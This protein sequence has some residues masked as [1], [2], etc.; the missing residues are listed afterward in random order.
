MQIDLKKFQETFFEEAAEHLSTMESGLLHL[1]ESGS[2]NEFLNTIFRAAHSIKGAAG[3]FDFKEIVRLTH[4]MENVLDKLR[5]NLLAPTADLTQILLR[6]SDRLREVVDA[7]H[8][9]EAGS[10][11]IDDILPELEAVLNGGQPSEAP[12]ADAA[13]PPGVPRGEVVYAVVFEPELE[14]FR[15]GQDLFLL[16]RELGELGE[17]LSSECQRS[18]LP[19]LD[20]LDPEHCY[21]GW[22]VRVRTARA[23]QE[24]RDVFMFV[25]GA[26]RLEVTAEAVTA[27]PEASAAGAVR[28]ERRAAADRRVESTS[29]RVSTEKV[30]GLINLVGELVISQAMVNQAVAALAMTPELEE[31]L[32]VVQRSTRELQE[33]VMAIRM[34]P[35]GTVF[36]RFPRLVHDL[37]VK[38]GK[39]ARLDIEGAETE[40]DKSVIEQLGDPLTHLIRNSIDHGIEDPEQRALAGKPEEGVITLRAYHEG[41]TVVIEVADDGKG[42]DRERIR[43][44]ALAQG[45]IRADQ[46]M[47][48]EEVNGLIFA[49]GFS[50]AA[51]VSDVSGRGVGMDVVKR[52]VESL[53]GAISVH[54][55]P[56]KGSRIR[57]RLP[58]TLA[59]L[60]GLSV[61]LGRDTFIV[62]LLSI[63]QSVRPEPS[64]IKTVLGG[65][66]E[67]FV[68]RGEPLPLVRLSRLFGVAGAVEDPQQGIVV[69]TENDGHRFGV[70][71]DDVLGQLQV[72]VKSI[73]RNYR[74]VEAVMGATILGD[75]RVAFIVDVAELHRV[76]TRRKSP[77]EDGRSADGAA[78]APLQEEVA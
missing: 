2:D 26:C 8:R 59:I 18:R 62:P 31:A 22:K 34:L 41:G 72:V 12:V 63:R 38:L 65:R 5:S 7:T 19:A 11:P 36:N 75:G 54:S 73:E 21:L 77:E 66:G 30:D 49:A 44:K 61:Q 35:I 40:L 55:T 24:L 39:R 51:V 52:N 74:K 43:A 50:T 20:E 4:V 69:V 1:E 13:A 3:S 67:V 78:A 45:L 25:E 58:L 76:A 37:T 68:L 64:D 28:T 32:M 27:A 57:I 33:Q 48:D 42:L 16:L 70:L 71:V 15:Q 46:P 17:I 53:N 14:F 60:D 9:G 10:V 6:A 23:A 47:T 29:I 56:G